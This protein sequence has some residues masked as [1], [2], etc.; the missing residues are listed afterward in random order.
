MQ[1]SYWL[2]LACAVI[3]LVWRALNA[4][5]VGI[6]QVEIGRTI[7]YMSFYKGAV[8]FLFIAVA[9]ANYTWFMSRKP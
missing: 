4:A 7:W 1:Y 9:T 2:G 3:A 5:G 6:A 8:L